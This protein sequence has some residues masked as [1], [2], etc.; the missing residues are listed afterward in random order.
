MTLSTS[1]FVTYTIEGLTGNV[2]VESTSQVYVASFG[3][4]TYATFGGYYSG[5]AFK[6]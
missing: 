5:F 6:P 2:W 3:A 1:D 4:Y